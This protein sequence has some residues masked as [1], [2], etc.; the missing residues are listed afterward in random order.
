MQLIGRPVIA[1]GICVICERA[2]TEGDA[3]WIDTERW[4]DVGVV[5][6]LTGKKYVC[7]SCA[8]EMAVKMGFASPGEFAD[9]RKQLDV[10]VEKNKALEQ[11]VRDLT[12]L[13]QALSRLKEDLPVDEA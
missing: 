6:F 2:H 3:D 7:P 4:F 10:I 8:G 5:T 11:R 9:F 13:E 1:P 12:V